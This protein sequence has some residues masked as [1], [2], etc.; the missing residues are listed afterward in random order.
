VIQPN[1]KHQNINGGATILFALIAVL[2]VMTC[3][4]F[5]QKASAQMD[6]NSSTPTNVTSSAPMTTPST[7]INVT[8]VAINASKSIEED[9]NSTRQAI[10]TGNIQEA[11][12]NLEQ[13]SQIAQTL[14]QCLTATVGENDTGFM[15]TYPQQQKGMNQSSSH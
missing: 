13:A 2:A 15:Q 4:P 14:P 11:L 3:F 1:H 8:A 6:N 12:N 9:L 5:V 7:P 10:L